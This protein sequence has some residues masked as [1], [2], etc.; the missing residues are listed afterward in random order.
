MLTS[1]KRYPEEIK[2]ETV[3]QVVDRGHSIDDVIK[4]LDIT[5]HRLYDWVKKFG[6]DSKKRNDLSEAQ[7]EI[8]RFQTELKRATEERDI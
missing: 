3:K 4:W 6:P 1:G 2:I 8:K 5:T 7:C